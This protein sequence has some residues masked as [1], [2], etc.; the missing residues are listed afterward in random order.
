[1]HFAKE[2]FV[3]RLF[4]FNF[5]IT[6]Y[7]FRAYVLY[8]KSPFSS[9]DYTKV[10]V[11]L[12]IRWIAKN[13]SSWKVGGNLETINCEKRCSNTFSNSFYAHICLQI[14]GF[15]YSLP[16]NWI[17]LSIFW[18]IQFCSFWVIADCYPWSQLLAFS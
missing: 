1:M 11:H 3:S 14:S 10:S 4:H 7:C 16:K 9:I 17:A 6:Y 12:H 2:D 8:G 13:C 5:G 18:W 15:I